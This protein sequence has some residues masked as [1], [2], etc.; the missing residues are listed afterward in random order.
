MSKYRWH[1]AAKWALLIRFVGFYDLRF[2][3][4]RTF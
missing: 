2:G 4:I 3:T 1:T